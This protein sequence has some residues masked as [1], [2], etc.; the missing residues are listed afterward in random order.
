MKVN[1]IL[2]VLAA[3]VAVGVCPHSLHG[4]EATRPTLSVNQGGGD[5]P[6]E[7]AINHAST[8]RLSLRL[9]DAASDGF[10]PG[11]LRIIAEDGQVIHPSELFNRGLRLD[12]EH[13]AHQWHVL[14]EPT[15]V[16]LPRQRLTIEAF[17][18][19][20]TELAAK[21][22]DLT[23]LDQAETEIRLPR[24]FTGRARS[25]RSGNT[26][27][28]LMHLSREQADR[29]LQTVPVGDDLDL[30]FVSHLRRVPD[31]KHYITNAYTKADLQ[32]LRNPQIEFGFGQE[33]RHNYLRHGEGYGH[34]MLLDM[35][36]LIRPVS[37]GPGIMGTGTDSPPLN[38][39]IRRAREQGGRTIWCHQALGLEDVPNWLL[40]MLDAQ[41]IFDG[42]QQS[43]YEDC[44][45][46]YLNV[47]LRVPFSTGTDWFIYDFSRAYVEMTGELSAARWLDALAGG[48]SFITNGPLLELLVDGGRPGD[49]LEAE[50]RAALPT[51]ARAWGRRDFGKLQL[52]QN[53]DV[54]RSAR[55]RRVGGHFE[56]EIKLPLLIA[57][58]SWVAA[59]I[60]GRLS[61]D[62]RAV[63]EMG[64]EIF[65]HTS[66][67]YVSY[68][69][70]NVFNFTAADQLLA[71]M[72][73]SMEKVMQRSRFANDD[74]AASVID[75]YRTGIAALQAMIQQ[76]GP[77]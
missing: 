29:Y 51:V 72:Q 74:E 37:I 47:G 60:D 56:S 19:L 8:C 35:D 69:G 28:H 53:G 21:T 41:N 3:S 75:V 57:E 5:R 52:V 25:L 55:A 49:E 34:V 39:G 12:D 26:H 9:I 17:S 22:I 10:L 67:V 42:S 20:E 6:A 13:P 36:E 40:G 71:E 73:T 15:E 64:A 1:A 30:L 2:L 59:R 23:G 70:E 58:P 63:N 45:Y 11:L 38:Q 44:F 61:D 33:H 14:T 24:F 4:H 18:G 27:L 48:R 54:I 16:E 46:P 76:A 43:N 77:R 50:D 62:R 32:N 65:G 7:V 66:A 68:R 31:E